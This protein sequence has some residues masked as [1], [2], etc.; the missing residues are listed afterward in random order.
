MADLAPLQTLQ[1]ILAAELPAAR[2]KL[3]SPHTDTGS[4]F[5]DVEWNGAIAIV[6]WRPSHGF[7]VADETAAFGEGPEFVTTD[8]AAAAFAAIAKLRAMEGARDTLIVAQQREFRDELRKVLLD[9]DVFSDTVADWDEAL[10]QLRLHVYR[11]V[12]VQLLP[13]STHARDEALH[14]ILLD[15]NLLTI[16][17]TPGAEDWMPLETPDWAEI[18]VRRMTEP[19]ELAFMIRGLLRYRDTVRRWPKVSD[20]AFDETK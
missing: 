19:R 1:R 2:A 15:S 16:A 11:S 4:W 14:T 3:D 6:E 10:S 9:V 5:L 13:E 7:G 18:F 12:I 20:A 8:A 17:V